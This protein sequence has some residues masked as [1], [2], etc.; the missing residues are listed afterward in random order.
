MECLAEAQL[1][2]A[3]LV[4]VSQKWYPL[5]LQ[6]REAGKILV[7]SASSLKSHKLAI[8]I[9]KLMTIRMERDSRIA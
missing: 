6:R 3:W 4:S 5:V 7:G 8:E 1:H 9:G 2:G